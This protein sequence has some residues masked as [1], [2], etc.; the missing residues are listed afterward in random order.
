MSQLVLSDNYPQ[1]TYYQS[2]HLRQLIW[3]VSSTPRFGVPFTANTQTLKLTTANMVWW[4]TTN[5]YSIW[6]NR[7]VI[8]CQVFYDWRNGITHQIYVCTSYLCSQL[9]VYAP[10]KPSRCDDD[11]CADV[12]CRRNVPILSFTICTLNV[13]PNATASTLNIYLWECSWLVFGHWIVN[14]TSSL[15]HT[16]IYSTKQIHLPAVQFCN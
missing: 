7:I 15:S 14:H 16:H 4:E 8:D 5:V 11:C 1:V 13:F 6:L 10:R 12:N 9:C 2:F 3:N